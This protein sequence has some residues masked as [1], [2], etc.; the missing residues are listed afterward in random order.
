M[1]TFLASKQWQLQD[2]LTWKSNWRVPVLSVSFFVTSARIGECGSSLRLGIFVCRISRVVVWKT[3][4]T[5][6]YS[7]LQFSPQWILMKTCIQSKWGKP[8]LFLL[9][10]R[11]DKAFQWCHGHGPT[12]LVQGCDSY[13]YTALQ[14]KGWKKWDW[15]IW[16][17]SFTYVEGEFTI[18]SSFTTWWSKSACLSHVGRAVWNLHSRWRCRWS[19]NPNKNKEL[20]MT[21]D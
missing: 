12:I 10:L 17:V 11:M 7:V 6:C 8:S 3:D 19:T 4:L 15:C 16:L 21:S 14:N 18:N 13:V 2:M 1:L 9:V 5:N 20:M